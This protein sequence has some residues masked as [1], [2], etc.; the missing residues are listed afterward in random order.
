MQGK[1]NKKNRQMI[2]DFPPEWT[3]GREIVVSLPFKK[4]CYLQDYI[5]KRSRWESQTKSGEWS[6]EWRIPI[7]NIGVIEKEKGFKTIV[8][9]EKTNRVENIDDATT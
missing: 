2:G 3:N 5:L 4:I 9:P 6:F 8:R 7:S 1:T